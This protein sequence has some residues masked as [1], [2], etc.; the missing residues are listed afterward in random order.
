MLAPSSPRYKS[1]ESDTVVVVE[2]LYTYIDNYHDRVAFRVLVDFFFFSK[3]IDI[4]RAGVMY[5][6]PTRGNRISFPL[7]LHIPTTPPR[8]C[9]HNV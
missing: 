2:C 7:S 5:F 6:A 1:Q 4:N 8:S 3:T 9:S